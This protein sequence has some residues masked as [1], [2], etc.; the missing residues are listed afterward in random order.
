M[1][2]YPMMLQ[3]MPAY[4]LLLVLLC[5]VIGTEIIV[6]DDRCKLFELLSQVATVAGW[7]KTP[8]RTISKN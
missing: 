4:E 2:Q 3:S 5:V 7:M 1:T 6:C 8:T